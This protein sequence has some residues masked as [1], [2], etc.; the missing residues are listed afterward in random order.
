MN[1]EFW[2]NRISKRP[3]LVAR[4]THLTRGDTDKE[5][6]ETLWNI[7][8]D[9]KLKATGRT[10][11]IVGDKKAVCFQEVPLY[12]IAQTLLF[13]EEER[14]KTEAEKEYSEKIRYSWFGLRLNKF[15]LFQ[16]GARP[17]IYGKTDDLKK[18][19]DSSVYWR[20]VR[21]DLDSNDNCIDWTHER[22]WRIEN[23]C[24]FEYE[25]VEV[26]VKDDRYYQRFVKRCIDE[27]K[28]D[29]L[30]KI[31]GVIPLNTVIS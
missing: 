31:H 12:S 4:L 27:N 14:A 25:D 2:R 20:I 22:E 16:R 13:E 15:D 21:L 6:F 29:M 3:D 8:L 19:L 1:R 18:V 26:I 7:L 11:Y 9:K 28:L 24:P 17:V 5:A 23:D 30:K 10:A